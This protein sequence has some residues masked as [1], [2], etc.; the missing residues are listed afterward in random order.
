MVINEKEN[1]LFYLRKVSSIYEEN[2]E[3]KFENPL[4]FISISIR[5][6]DVNKRKESAVF[7][8]DLEKL[9][10]V[11]SIISLQSKVADFN[12]TLLCWYC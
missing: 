10:G 7:Y 5:I 8:A 2:E 11:N 1:E 6:I 12:Q 3:Y 9:K 4:D